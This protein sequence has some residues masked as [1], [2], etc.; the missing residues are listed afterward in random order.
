[1]LLER[2]GER[3]KPKAIWVEVERLHEGGTFN[4]ERKKEEEGVRSGQVI[5]M[6]RDIARE[7]RAALEQKM[8]SLVN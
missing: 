5:V 1:V 2:C 4:R 3:G 8:E 7:A 6:E